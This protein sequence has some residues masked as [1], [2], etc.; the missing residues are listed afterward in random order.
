[1]EK[2]NLKNEIKKQGLSVPK[3]SR[4]IGI[5]SGETPTP[6]TVWGWVNRG[7]VPRNKKWLSALA[8]I[9]NIKFGD[10]F[11]IR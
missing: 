4:M 2:L 9:F 1:M 10:Q 5:V 6:V 7:R 3:L 8:K 11:F